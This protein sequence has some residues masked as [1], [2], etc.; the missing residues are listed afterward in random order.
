MITEKN[1]II[2]AASPKALYKLVLTITLEEVAN[3]KEENGIDLKVMRNGGRSFDDINSIG[4]KDDKFLVIDGKRKNL[5]KELIDP[6][7]RVV[8]E[9]YYYDGYASPKIVLHDRKYKELCE[10]IT[11]RLLFSPKSPRVREVRLYSIPP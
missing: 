11:N 1:N 10:R 7:G 9:I 5:L 2:Y 6:I 4:N 3:Y 8:A